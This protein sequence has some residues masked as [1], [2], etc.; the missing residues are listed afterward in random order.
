MA[1]V[2][3]GIL[4]MSRQHLAD[5]PRLGTTFRFQLRHIAGR[6][7]RSL[8]EQHFEN[9]FAAKHRA[10]A[11]GRGGYGQH[12]RLRKQSTAVFREAPFEVGSGEQGRHAVMPREIGVDEGIIG[13]E[14]ERNGLVAAQD[15]VGKQHGLLLHRAQQCRRGLRKPFGIRL[16]ARAKP[17]DAQPLQRE[18]FHKPPR[19]FIGEEA[20]YFRVQDFLAQ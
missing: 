18:P 14:Q 8:A 11:A 9:P 4:A 3:R 1:A 19:A 10:R 17:V 13:V 20:F 6:R 7:R 15:G 16:D 2:A 5:G 12:A